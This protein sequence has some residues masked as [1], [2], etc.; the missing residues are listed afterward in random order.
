MVNMRPRGSYA[1][2]VYRLLPR[3]SSLHLPLILK[4]S[5]MEEHPKVVNGGKGEF[6]KAKGREREIKSIMRENLID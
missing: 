5:Q 6:Q 4:S 1:Q 2:R 3:I